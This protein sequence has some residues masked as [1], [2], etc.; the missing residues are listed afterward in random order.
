M[1]REGQSQTGDESLPIAPSVSLDQF[2]ARRAPPGDA[3]AEGTDDVPDR[4]GLYRIAGPLQRERKAILLDPQ[5]SGGLLFAV[6][7][8][9]A[10]EV[11]SRF[12]EAGLPV[13]QVGEVADGRGVEVIA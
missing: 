8:E 10:S 13:W 6:G 12:A 5:T 1:Q 2:V 9:K 7:A 3:A 4:I 11:G